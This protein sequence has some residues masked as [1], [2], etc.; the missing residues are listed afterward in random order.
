MS[1]QDRVQT[2]IAVAMRGGDALRRDVLRMVASAA[3]NVE[4]REGR[5]LT[6]DEYLA[7]LSREVKTRRESVEA[8]RAGG[9][10]DLAAKEEAEIAIIGEYLP[11]ALT[12][13]E[14]AALV[15]EG[16]AATGASSARDMGKVMGWLA[17][18]TRGR[19]DGKHVSELVVQALAERGPRRPR[20]RDPLSA[21][22]MTR[23]MLTRRI[24]TPTRFTRRDVP[25]LVIAAGILILALAAILGADI[26][27]DQPLDAAEGQLATRD[28]VAPTRDRLR[29][30]GPDRR[31]RGRPPARRSPFQYDFTTENA[32]AIAAAQQLAFEQ[33]RRRAI[34]TT[35]AADHLRGGQRKALLKTAVLDLSDQARDDA[36]RPRRRA[37]GR[38]SG[39]RR[40]GSSTRR[41]RTELRDTEVDETRTRLSGRMAGGLDEAERMLAA[42]LIAPLV[43]PNSSL[44]LPLTDD[45]AGGGGGRASQPVRVTIRQGEVIVRNGVAVRRPPTSRRSTP[46]GLR[47]TRAGRHELRRLG[48]CSRSSSSGCC[49]P[50]SG[51]SGRACG[52]ATTC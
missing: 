46:S 31:R 34:D 49:W 32:I 13:D 37:L 30:Q 21:D 35:F 48:C 43:V 20:R 10:E 17:P 14:I 38:R 41:E 3:Y 25:R 2:D 22:P 15:H 52:T 9:R 50:G 28:I 11:A 51:A 33:P 12:E 36:R 26:L 5:P 44:S 23:P 19:A 47:Q 39:P 24:D 7:V 27:P 18:R 1:L 45:R 8:F 42:E 29:E 6:D 40:R 16:I 4:K